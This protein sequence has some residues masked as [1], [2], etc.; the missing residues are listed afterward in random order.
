MP[1]SDYESSV[2]IIL[3][4]K[5]GD[6]LRCSALLERD[7]EYLCWNRIT[8]LGSH[9]DFIA[10]MRLQGR[11]EL[12]WELHNN[13][14]WPG[15]EVRQDQHHTGGTATMRSI[16]MAS[17]IS[18]AADSIQRFGN[19]RI[20]EFS[21][22][23]TDLGSNGQSAEYWF[24][25][26]PRDWYAYPRRMRRT[27]GISHRGDWLKVPGTGLRF[28]L[29]SIGHPRNDPRLSR[30]TELIQLPGVEMRPTSE[31][32]DDAFLEEADDLWFALRILIA[33]RH[34]IYPH[35]VAEFREVE[36]EY[37]R[38][39][40]PV[41]VEPRETTDESVGPP[42]Y[43]A[44]DRFLARG[45]ASLLPHKM[46]RELLH[47][48]VFGY[49]NSFKTFLLE[50]GLTSCV[51]A[52]ERL[53]TA[54]EVISSLDREVMD[55]GQWRKVATALKRS[56]DGLQLEPGQARQV[57]R[58]LAS[59]ATLSLEERILRMAATQRR[60]WKDRDRQLLAGVADMIR[61]RNA[62]VH[63]RLADDINEVFVE[64]VRARALF[65]VLF[66]NFLNCSGFDR[67]GH[68]HMIVAHHREMR[69]ERH[70]AD[71]DSRADDAGD[72][73]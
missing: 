13:P 47:A 35:T 67:S 51:E 50:G 58:S 27:T 36:G 22:R 16:G 45:A 40:H 21:E 46:H 3:I 23:T 64:L 48:A 56:V 53:V 42:F 43:G 49:A 12:R 32:A 11:G 54:F 41:A 55:R 62:I 39:W 19:L 59:P 20:F 63:G 29:L 18:I 60:R 34:R 25:Q 57:K 14:E 73:A 61:L 9:D 4:G 8:L 72:A 17:G 33:F 30:E 1:L 68:A 31:V 66:L 6:T 2:S 65:E 38:K 71:G 52:I 5:G 24:L 69:S 15:G 10:A 26:R 44:I 28:R 7:P 70:P 37:S